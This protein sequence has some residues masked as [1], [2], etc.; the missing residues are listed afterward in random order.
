MEIE[1]KK[2]I[3]RKKQLEQ[4]QPQKKLIHSLKQELTQEEKEEKL[5]EEKAKKIET[6]LKEQQRQQLEKYEKK[7]KTSQES[8]QPSIKASS[9]AAQLTHA[10]ESVKTINDKLSTNQKIN[11]SYGLWPDNNYTDYATQYLT[12]HANTLSD[13]PNTPNIIPAAE[14]STKNLWLRWHKKTSFLSS[15]DKKTTPWLA[16]IV[17]I[18]Q[19]QGDNILQKLTVA[20]KP[21]TALLTIN[22]IQK[23]TLTLTRSGNILSGTLVVER[24]NKKPETQNIYF[25]IQPATQDTPEVYT[26]LATRGQI[27][28]ARANLLI[29]RIKNLFS[30]WTW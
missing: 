6:A 4:K 24:K 25:K 7:I 13:N 19:E 30:P 21:P 5:L 18:S 22:L 1:L 17:D 15:P 28:M 12:Q 14:N 11:I 9:L 20:Y 2:D 27:L 23:Q 10:I 8:S 26:Y 3:E 29:T 16:F